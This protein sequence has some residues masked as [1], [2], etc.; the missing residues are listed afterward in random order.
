MNKLLMTILALTFGLSVFAKE[1]IVLTDKNTM[2]LNSQVDTS[3]MGELTSA[4]V[5]LN[6][7][8]TKEPIYLV[9]NS[10]GGSV[11]DGFDF[12]RYAKT[13]RR[14]IHTVTIFAASMA[15]QIVEALGNRYVTDFSTLMS[16]RASGGMQ[17][18][19]PGQV[20]S[21]YSH[22]LSHVREQDAAVIKRT[23]G[24]QTAESYAK[25]IAD[26]YWA[27]STKAINDGFADAEVSLSCDSSLDGTV[28]KSFN[29]IF[30][31]VDVDF[32][33]CPLIPFPLSIRPSTGKEYVEKNNIDVVKEFNKSQA[34]FT[35]I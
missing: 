30:F 29:L 4:L 35:K 34:N 6:K 3:S 23:K 31:S 26:E 15:F 8:D 12:I 27:N 18:T 2:F 19:M 24:K 11:Y 9:I 25:L 28:T 14:P 22:F 13:S 32:S 21:R 10:P 7:I 17:G 33:R 1:K 5:N 20:D 16:H